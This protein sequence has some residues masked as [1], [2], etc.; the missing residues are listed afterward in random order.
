MKKTLAVMVLSALLM[1]LPLGAEET[2]AK[3]ESSKQE[4]KTMIDYKNELGL[5]EAQV[6]SVR[7]ALVGFQKT[8]KTE[9]EALAQQEKEFQ[10]LLQAEAPLADIKAKL[11]QISDT[12][13]NLRYADVLTSRR[14]KE[15]LTPEQMEKWRAIQAKVRTKK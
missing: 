9:R 12:R 1:T 13:F 3:K 8:I 7:D 14:V 6:N 4:V 15:A 10:S 2:G 5:S 11:R